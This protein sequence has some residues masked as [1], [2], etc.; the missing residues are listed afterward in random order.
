MT[1]NI[2]VRIRI[3][4]A[5]IGNL[6]FIGHLDLQNL[7]ERA[8]RR[9]DL[10]MQF[11]QGFSPKVRLNLASALPLGITSDCEVVDFWLVRPTPLDEVQRA[12]AGALPA[13]L[14]ISKLEFVPLTLPSLQS[15]IQASEYLVTFGAEVQAVEL[16]ARVNEFVSATEI[17]RIRREKPYNLRALTQTL[18]VVANPHQ[19]SLLMRL[20]SREGATGRPDEVIAQLGFDPFSCE[21]KRIKLIF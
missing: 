18:E 2:P 15:S 3:T 14:Q 13:E 21:I 12:L 7:W 20:D 8:F 19:L 17:I 6:R 5:K 10:P 1:E 11:S 4:Y 16:L 9:A